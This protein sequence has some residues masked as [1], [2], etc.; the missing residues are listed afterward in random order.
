MAD[1]TTTNLGLTK[2]EVG[3]SADTWGTKLNTDLD[4]VDALF[5]AAGT[6]TSV[7]LNVGA[8]KTLTI[9]GNVSANGATISPTELSYL[10][11]VSS[12]IQ[13]QLNAKEPTITTLPVSKGG[14]GASSFTA[15]YHLKGNGTSAVASSVIYDDGTNVGV[16]TASPGY[17]LQV[18]GTMAGVVASGA[19]YS[20]IRTSDFYYMTVAA[21]G[22]STLTDANGSA[23]MLFRTG[24]TERMRL[25]ASG[26]VGI[27]TSSP[28]EKLNVYVASG[29]C[30]L[31]LESGANN[32]AYFGP[33]SSGDVELSVNGATT[34]NIIF[35]SGAS[36]S[37]TERM[38]IDSSGNVGIGTSSPSNLLHLERSSGNAILRIKDTSSTSDTYYISDSSGTSITQ[39][40]SLPVILKT[41]NTER[42]RISSG[43]YVAIGNSNAGPKFSVTL[44]TGFSWGGGWGA[45]SAVF[46]GNGAVSGAGTGGVGI[47]YD[48]T[49]GGT[50]GT[51]IPG[52]AWKPLRL[53]SDNLQFCTNGATE[54][55]RIDSSGNLLV[56][57]TSSGG[58]KFEVSASNEVAR[59]YNTSGT[60]N[61]RFVTSANST[62][63]YIQWSGST[64][65]YA[66]SSD[67]RLKDIAGPIM[68]SGAYID[69]LR[70]VQGSWKADGSRFIGLIAH[71]VQEVSE[72]KV[73]VGVKDGE[74]MQAMDY[75]SPEIIANLIAELQSLRARV[76]ELEGK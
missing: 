32:K 74:E 67:Y 23:P 25:D 57:T 15:G 71:E 54:R 12:N 46:G 65:T 20:A 9:A 49:D 26:N 51:V 40:G 70:P 4:Q 44:G 66:T 18:N 5:A 61:I 48:D 69:A 52:V 53:F 47:T 22:L 7:G 62:I 45:G 73:A 35:K 8:G 21:D 34:P 19:N 55:M 58:S 24:S 72:T 27:G 3:A 36:S 33:V 41:A 59:F 28:S 43:G 50:I 64:T 14:T 2:P 13:T 42:M 75:S 16:G 10:D 31:L 6:G 68:N 60:G 37:Y 63:G 38:R 17:K 39:T 76:A 56:G 29:N 11:T 1:T 30:R